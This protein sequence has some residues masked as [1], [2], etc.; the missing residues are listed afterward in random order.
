MKK[1][2]PDNIEIRSTRSRGTAMVNK[3]YQFVN[4]EII[5]SAE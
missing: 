4:R 3:Q 5:N 2:F 1:F